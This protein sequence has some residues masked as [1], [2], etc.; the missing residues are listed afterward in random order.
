[1]KRFVLLLSLIACNS[2]AY[3]QILETIGAEAANFLL[4]N[5]KTANTFD[6][7]ERAVLSSVK[8]VL[9]ISAQRRH[10]MN[11]AKTG[12]TLVTQQS[13]TVNNPRT[14]N[15]SNILTNN[16]NNAV[17]ALEEDG[18]MYVYYQGNKYPI[19]KSLIE[20]AK[21]I[22]EYTTIVDEGKLEDYNLEALK[23][24]WQPAK[25]TSKLIVYNINGIECLGDIAKKEN[26]SLR[27]IYYSHSFK[28]SYSA[29]QPVAYAGQI[30]QSTLF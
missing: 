17:I 24:S 8:N 30:D 2:I 22:R 20:Q 10:E 6:P 19:A 5:P 14:I 15:N 29:F 26:I 27:D 28:G 25:E 16:Q 9:D 1:M 11:V 23:E 12:K 3:S 4:T 18:S 7:T 21:L 13:T